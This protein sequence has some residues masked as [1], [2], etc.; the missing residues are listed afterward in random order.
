MVPSLTRVK[1]TENPLFWPRS[2]LP[3]PSPRSSLASVAPLA[4]AVVKSI[5]ATRPTGEPLNARVRPAELNSP[6][7]VATVKM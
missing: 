6:D 7:A 2:R 1:T 5:V 3:R 4:A